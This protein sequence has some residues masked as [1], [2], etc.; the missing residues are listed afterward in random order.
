MIASHTDMKPAINQQRCFLSS[1]GS[2][3]SKVVNSSFPSFCIA[4]R[5][6]CAD[7]ELKTDDDHRNKI[8]EYF[9]PFHRKKI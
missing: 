1:S 9:K 3:Y 8:V 4:H 2:G 5:Q 6:G 7:M